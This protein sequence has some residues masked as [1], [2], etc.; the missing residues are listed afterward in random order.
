MIGTYLCKN[1]Y[2][3]TTWLVRVA[4]KNWWVHMTQNYLSVKQSL[5]GKFFCTKLNFAHIIH[6]DTAK[7]VSQK[8][9]K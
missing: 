8:R 6:Q 1:Q 3:F 7:Q 2:N 4:K 9:I 5:D